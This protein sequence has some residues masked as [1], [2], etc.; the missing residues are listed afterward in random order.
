VQVDT[1]GAYQHERK[2]VEVALVDGS[3]RELKDIL[4]SV[5][6]MWI[7]ELKA[8]GLLARL[9][10]AA[11]PEAGGI[12]PRQTSSGAGK[13]NLVARKDLR[14]RVNYRRQKYNHTTGQVEPIDI[15]GHNYRMNIYRPP[16]LEVEIAMVHDETGRRIERTVRLSDE[17]AAAYRALKTDAERAQFGNAIAAN[18]RDLLRELV[19]EARDSGV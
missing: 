3:T 7:A 1:D 10:P 12:P 16:E 14:F 13:M 18:H 5:L 9:Q 19:R 15:T 4:R 2:T 8:M 6:D 11:P 17:E